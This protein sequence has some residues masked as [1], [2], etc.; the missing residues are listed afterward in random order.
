MATAAPTNGEATAT[1][2]NE[3]WNLPTDAFVDILLRLSPI[4]R[5]LARL[6]C[7]HWRHVIDERTPPKIPPP[8]VLA[9]IDLWI[10]V[11][12]LGVDRVGV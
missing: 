8:K 7:R 11:D 6:V 5:R 12:R 3:G 1:V 10:Y 4:C 2:N 9:L